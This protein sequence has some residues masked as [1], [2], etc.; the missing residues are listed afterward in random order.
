M[1]KIVETFGQQTFN[2][3]NEYTPLIEG[4]R[5]IMPEFKRIFN[6]EIIPAFRLFKR[7]D[8]IE[9][10]DSL[11]NSQRSVEMS[12]QLGDS[13]N[14]LFEELLLSSGLNL[15]VEQADGYDWV[16]ENIR[17]TD[18]EDKNAM[19][20][21][22]SNRIWVGNSSSGS[23]VSM[24]LLKRFELNEKYEIVGA[25]ISLVN[26]DDTTTNWKKGKGARSTLSFTLND[27]NGIIT[28]YGHWI[29]K[30]KNIFPRWE[31]I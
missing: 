6:E 9:Y 23:K 10:F 26:L 11:P 13:I 27:I 8:I 29:G 28:I 3:D 14:N 22:P 4:I 30:T 16:Y 18:I 20:Q 5:S 15:I 17:H 24:H 7:K 2:A 19:S 25:H 1:N 21:K 12:K 31:K